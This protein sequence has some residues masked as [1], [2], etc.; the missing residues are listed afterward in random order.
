M[1]K[2]KTGKQSRIAQMRQVYRMTKQ[3]DR[4]IGLIMLGAFVG[5]TLAAFLILSFIPPGWFWLD[6]ATSVMFGLLAALIVFSRRATSAQMDQIRG[7]PGAA[8]AALSVLRRGWR[9]DQMIAF[10]RN[11]DVVHRVVGRP[12]IVLIGEGHPGR[13]KQLL[14]TER[15]RHQ[16]VVSEVPVHQIVVGDGEGQVPLDKLV[17][18]VN[19]LDRALKPA[20][21]TEV[22]SRLKAIDATRSQVPLPK[23]P[24]PTSMKG[25]RGNMRG[26]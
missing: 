20:E 16:R 2:K 1:A 23:G 6:L 25:M 4:W 11:Q 15:T 10:N 3:S 9:T 17:K 7:K 24:V 21:L 26:R 18:H 19:K 8:L 22:L 12:G 14:S 5:A 13:L